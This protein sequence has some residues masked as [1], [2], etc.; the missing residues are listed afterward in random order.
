MLRPMQAPWCRLSEPLWACLV[1]S[2]GYILM[3][4]QDSPENCVPNIKIFSGVSRWGKEKGEVCETSP[5]EE[6]SQSSGNLQGTLET[7]KADGYEVEVTPRRDCCLVMHTICPVFKPTSS[8]TWG[9][10]DLLPLWLCW[11]HPLSCFSALLVSLGAHWGSGQAFDLPEPRLWAW[12]L[13]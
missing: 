6:I 1:D 12:K 13:H 2:A 5:R 8:Q 11:I 4:R 10:P 9:L 7:G 3:V